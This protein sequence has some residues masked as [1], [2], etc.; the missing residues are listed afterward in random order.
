MAELEKLHDE[1][2]K[3]KEDA[4]RLEEAPR[5]GSARAELADA[6]RESREFKKDLT[7]ARISTRRRH[8]W[9]RRTNV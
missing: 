7:H 9:T 5:H 6:Q 4:R 1:L 8:D 2:D 3:S